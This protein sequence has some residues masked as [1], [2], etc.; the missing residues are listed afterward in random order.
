MVGGPCRPNIWHASACGLARLRRVSYRGA[1]KDLKTLLDPIASGQEQMVETVIELSRQNSGSFNL[2]GLATMLDLAMA[3]FQPYCERS[4]KLNL[5]PLETISDRGDVT[6]RPLGQAGRL[7]TRPDAPIQLLFV[8]H[9]DTVFGEGHA[10]QDVVFFEPNI[11]NG[12]GVADM[13]GGLV[14]LQAALAAFEA[15]P[16]SAEVGWEIILN[17]DEELGS[18]ASG[19]LL[20]ASALG[21]H[22]GFIF[23]PTFP[24]G[25]LASERKGSGTFHI[26]AR[27]R[28]A[29]AGRDHHLG[30]NAIAGLAEAIGRIQGLNGRWPETTVNVGYVH[31]GGPTNIVPDTAVAKFNVRVP[32]AETGT[33]LVEAL[34][35]IAS[36]LEVPDVIFDVGGGFTRPPKPLTGSGLRLLEFVA[37]TASELG[38]HV[39]WEPTGGVSDGNNLSAAGLTN[40]DNIGVRGGNIHSEEEFLVVQSLTERARL[41]AALLM[42]IGAGEFDPRELG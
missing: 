27:G 3:L 39:G 36:E 6:T 13:K 14:V 30:R 24:N 33:E 10:F 40:V 9:Y 20:A 19:A 2:P 21:K 23:E 31:G 4:E 8:G 28:A 42:K 5:P 7:L 12:P 18:V 1:V 15:S 32:D 16:W 17:P 35:R 22:A 34:R 25:N 26:I 29:H 11:L 38:L 41:A 37:G